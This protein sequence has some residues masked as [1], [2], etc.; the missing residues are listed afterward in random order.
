MSLYIIFFNALSLTNVKLEISPKHTLTLY[1]L[2]L[3]YRFK[4]WMAQGPSIDFDIILEFN[5]THPYN[6]GLQGEE[7]QSI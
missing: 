5:L 1:F 2:D 6:T 3:V 4:L 7:R